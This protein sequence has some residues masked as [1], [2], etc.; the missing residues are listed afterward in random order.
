MSAVRP[1]AP[2][3]RLSSPPPDHD[4]GAIAR[5]RAPSTQ[6]SSTVRV[7]PATTGTCDQV[8]RLTEP[9]FWF[10]SYSVPVFKTNGFET[11][12]VSISV[13]PR[14]RC[15]MPSPNLTASTTT[16]DGSGTPLAQPCGGR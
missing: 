9:A 10:C 11:V 12:G 3:K 1:R 16:R 8:G 13:P 14:T 5:S 2:S 7:A 6:A 4:A 15:T